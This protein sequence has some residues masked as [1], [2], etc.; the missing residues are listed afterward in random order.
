MKDRLFFFATFEKQRFMIGLPGL[1]TEPS[2]SVS[3]AGH[4]VDGQA[5]VS[6][7]IPS[8]TNL[9]AHL[10][11]AY[12]LTGPATP[13]NYSSPDP[14][15]GY[16]Y[17]GLAKID[18][19]INDK[20]TVSFHYFVGQ[21]NQVAPVGGSALSEAASELKYYYEVAPIHVSNYAA[22]LELH[23]VLTLS[24]QVLA[25]VNYFHQTFSDDNTSFDLAAR[26]WILSGFDLPGAPNIQHYRI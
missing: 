15:F 20:N 7:K 17:N 9:L 12:A 22:G 24:N 10:W 16:S 1:G 6:P 3:G 4:R 26:A 11:P 13:D 2:A 8:A 14:E 5:M 25:G 19:K 18:Y 23:M 21:G